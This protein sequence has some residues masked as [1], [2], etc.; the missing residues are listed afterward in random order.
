MLGEIRVG[1]VGLE[2][3]VLLGLRTTKKGAYT[4]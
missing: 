4:I 1:R 2:R 3:A